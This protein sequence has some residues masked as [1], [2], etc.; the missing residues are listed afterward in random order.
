[1]RRSMFFSAFGALGAAF[2][3]L[4]AREANAVPMLIDYVQRQPATPGAA[5]AGHFNITGVARAGSFFGSGATLTSLNASAISSGTLADARLSANIAQLNKNNQ[6]SASQTFQSH[7]NLV[8][9]NGGITFPTPSLNSAVPMISMFGT[10]NSTYART[11]LG[12]DS[13]TPELG[14]R[15]LGYN[16]SFVFQGAQ[17]VLNVDLDGFVT[18]GSYANPG[19]AVFYAAGRAGVN[20]AGRFYNNGSTYA[21]TAN[22]D[23]LLEANAYIGGNLAVGTGTP[24]I[25]LAI[26]DSDTGFS[27]SPGAV[28]VVL[29]GNPELS[30]RSG[31]VGLGTTAPAVDLAIDDADTGFNASAG[32]LDLVL[33]NASK[34]FVRSAGL[35]IGK[36]PSAA[37][38]VVGSAYFREAGSAVRA[39]IFTNATNDCGEIWTQSSSGAITAWIASYKNGATTTGIVAACDNAGATQAWVDVTSAGQGR[40]IADVKNFR[41]INPRDP[42]TDIYYAS[43]EGPEAAMYVRGKGRLVNGR[44]MIDL[45]D[46]FTSLA[47]AETL[48]IQLTPASFRSK[49]LGYEV[50]QDGSIVIGELA[51]GRGSYEFSWVVTAVRKGF[52]DYEV[53]RSWK[54]A[55]MTNMTEQEAWAARMKKI[56]GQKKRLPPQ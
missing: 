17:P 40:V 6:F 33:D 49:G 25:D 8:A 13:D 41:A 52:E 56:D 18:A 45:P 43:L 26:D 20:A 50:G 39:R 10:G 19:T 31:K 28:D 34:I 21:L 15:F 46:H 12:V 3:V 30:V 27:G 48:T 4:G 24:S 37:L 16:N 14:L 29:N 1:M 47:N 23:V 36:T 22:G 44:A 5:E 9:Q 38:D 54:E 53:I 42:Q 32:A 55:P 11:I 51:D 7:L 2:V 35:G